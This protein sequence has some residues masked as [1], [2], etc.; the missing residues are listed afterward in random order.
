MG[1]I[2][3]LTEEQWIYNDKENVLD[4]L[5]PGN[6]HVVIITLA[7]KKKLLFED[8]GGVQRCNF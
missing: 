1:S 7:R 5:Y 6:F 4:H 8:G 2:E 3:S